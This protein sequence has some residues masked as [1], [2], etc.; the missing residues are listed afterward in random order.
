MFGNSLLHI[1]NNGNVNTSKMSDNSDD[2]NSGY[3]NDGENMQYIDID[4]NTGNGTDTRNSSSADLIL[5]AGTN[6]IKLARLYW[7]G[8]IDNSDFDLSTTANK[9]IKLRKGTTNN[10]TDVTATGIDQSTISNG[11]TQYQ[12]YADV[13]GFITQNGGGTYTIGNVPLTT[14]SID[15]GGNH[16]GWSIVV[17]Y[18]N[19]L[20]NYNSIRLYDGFQKVYD[21]GASTVANVKCISNGV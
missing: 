14:G 21:E 1:I 19:N 12:A 9:T 7:G 3:G 11:Y 13:T 8:R 17:V 2:G 5:P 15:G 20:L 16:G 10:Y 18:E 4:G 6:T